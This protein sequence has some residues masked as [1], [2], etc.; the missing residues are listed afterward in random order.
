MSDHCRYIQ[1]EPHRIV[2]GRHLDGCDT[3][4]CHGCQ[5][6][7]QT[8][9]KDCGIEHAA[10]VCPGCIGNVRDDIGLIC[11]LY[12]QLPDQAVHSHA[13]GRVG[14]DPLGGAAM[15]ML[16]PM[17]NG[18]SL[19]DYDEWATVTDEH[20]L[21]VLWTWEEA[22]REW[23]DS[24]TRLCA[25]IDRSADYLR[26][27]LTE[28]AAAPPRDPWFPPDW[29]EMARDIRAARGRLE[30]CLHDG[31]RQQSG[32]PCTKCSTNLIRVT[33]R[34]GAL[35]D[36]WQC[37]NRTCRRTYNEQQYRNAVTAGYMLLQA[38]EVNGETWATPARTAAEVKRGKRT[39][40]TW[41]R[42]GVIRRA[43]IIAGRRKV[44]SVDDARRE[45]S[46]RK[47]RIH[48]EACA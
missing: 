14:A 2:P 9:C 32:A 44:V 12:A 39:I 21:H 5:P 31:E 7:T 11:E 46:E 42:E 26:E 48:G 3:D 37:P 13:D 24:P 20:P 29:C 18:L 16:G 30:N 25:R 33:D 8:H 22:W 6:C 45:D 43:C 27:H 35:T 47:R 41:A 23:W 40:E 1:G 19:P 17:S 36:D 34:N 10:D 15:V 28:M 4:E 38:E